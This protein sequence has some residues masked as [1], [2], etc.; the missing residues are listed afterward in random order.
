MYWIS[1]SSPNC[2]VRGPE[3]FR[4]SRQVLPVKCH[5]QQWVHGVTYNGT[6]EGTEEWVYGMTYKGTK[7]GQGAGCN[8][9]RVGQNRMY[10]C[11]HCI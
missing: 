1:S 10:A 11:I 3:P 7:E 2:T 6:K 9:R 4:I 5:S 8:M